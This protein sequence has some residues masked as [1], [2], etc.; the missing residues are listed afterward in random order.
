LVGEEM[1][2]ELG[3]TTTMG[4]SVNVAIDINGS[5][6]EENEKWRSI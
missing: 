6:G 2:F 1:A 5:A 4:T 3:I